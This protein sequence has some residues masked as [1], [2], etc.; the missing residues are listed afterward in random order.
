MLVIWGLLVAGVLSGAIGGS[1]ASGQGHRYLAGTFLVA[2]TAVVVILISVALMGLFTRR[3]AADI[4]GLE[5]T[6]EHLAAEEMPQLM[7]K[8]R[9]GEPV[10]AG[11]AQP[12]TRA[13]TAEVAQAEA[14]I[15]SLARSAAAAAG[16]EARLRNGIRQVFVSLARRNQSLL[17]RQ[18]RLIDALEQ[19][20]SDPATLADLFPL[21]HLTTRMRRHAE[22]LIIL[23][24][25][26]PGRSWSEPV[27]VI[28]VIRGAVAE[29]EDYKRVSVLARAADAVAGQAVADM[30]HL[31]AELIENAT[32]FSPSGTRVEVRA[33]QVAN[34]FA[35][36][37]DDRG[38]GIGA[39]QLASINAQL[40]NPPDFDLA[41][42]DQLGLFVVGKLA[43]RHGVQVGL[44]PSAAGGTTAVVL[45]PANLVV[46]LNVAGAVAPPDLR[47]AP[48]RGRHE[49][50]PSGAGLAPGTA[51]SAAGFSLG[52]PGPGPDFGGPGSLSTRSTDSPRPAPRPAS[53]GSGA[54]EPSAAILAAP[55][56]APPPSGSADDATA[57]A[58]GQAALPG[59]GATAASAPG[60]A[61]AGPQPGDGTH[62]GLPRRVRQAS[63]NPHLRQ[64]PAGPDREGP[65]ARPAPAASRS[66]E[67]ARMLVSS[68]QRGWQRGRAA[69]PAATQSTA[70]TDA[71]A[72]DEP[73]ERQDADVPQPGEA[74][75]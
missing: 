5:T 20:A 39:K 21:D 60:P 6:T 1:G 28:D 2:G 56:A 48:D 51:A 12:V 35:I 19:K 64:P 37:V 34:G 54:A 70:S 73:D 40:A 3:I 26:A 59:Q 68:L 71:A 30:V 49:L 31:L 53:A 46:P 72:T 29:I 24:G 13:A 74:R 7:D 15:A 61:A 50:T 67:E 44:R 36:E 11:Q 32:L 17:H 43:A 9:R 23:S 65:A 45:M 25:V 63:L 52:P 27:P 75:S 69:E 62:R 41:N 4:G 10:T 55:A 47:Q 58:E 14:A 16:A 18:L 38:L 57:G 42:A 8:L 33:G 22:G 66:P